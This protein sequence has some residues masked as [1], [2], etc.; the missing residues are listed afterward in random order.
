MEAQLFRWT[1]TNKMNMWIQLHDLSS[2][3]MNGVNEDQAKD[4]LSKFDWLSELVKRDKSEDE[5]C[6]P[7]LGLIAN[8]G[9]IL[10]ICPQGSEECYIH[11]H[12]PIQKKFLGLIPFSDQGTH[13]IMKST[14]STAKILIG[15]HFDEN[16]NE[17]L[18]TN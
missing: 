9:S 6:D 5:V 1:E 12:Y 8:D 17:I 2:K 18:K 15:H 16:R 10:H 14:I 11:Y 13:S 7:G 3:E 4:A